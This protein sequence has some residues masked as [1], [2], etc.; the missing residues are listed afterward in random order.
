MREFL[1]VCRKWFAQTLVCAHPA[2]TR[3][4]S[5]DPPHHPQ[6]TIGPAQPGLEPRAWQGWC[7]GWWAEGGGRGVVAVNFLAPAPLQLG[8]QHGQVWAEG[9]W[10]GDN[11]LSVIFQGRVA[12]CKPQIPLTSLGESVTTDSGRRGL[13]W[14]LYFF[15]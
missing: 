15:Y 1:R 12:S 4:L 13:R 14:G 3:F 7:R 11:N 10:R 8:A 2:S 9:E 5:S 6:S